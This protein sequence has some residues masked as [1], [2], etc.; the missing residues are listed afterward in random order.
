MFVKIGDIILTKSTS[1]QYTI[2]HYSGGSIGIRGRVQSAEDMKSTE[3]ELYKLREG[4]VRN[5]EVLTDDGEELTGSYKLNELHWD[6]ERQRNGNEYEL[7]FNIGL[8]K[9]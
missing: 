1:A 5:I 2:Q 6:K 9:Q 8:Q 7:A 4:T 3:T